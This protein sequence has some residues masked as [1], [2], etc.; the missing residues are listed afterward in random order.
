MK[1]TTG[2]EAQVAPPD[3]AGPLALLFLRRGEPQILHW[4]GGPALEY[5]PLQS[6]WSS[7]RAELTVRLA[8]REAPARAPGGKPSRTLCGRSEARSKVRSTV[9]L[10]VASAERKFGLLFYTCN[11][12]HSRNNTD[13]CLDRPNALRPDG[14]RWGDGGS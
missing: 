8:K 9:W 3:A 5:T 1:S 2:G 7:V 13:A 4:R 10:S 6:A 12:D 11:E 14:T